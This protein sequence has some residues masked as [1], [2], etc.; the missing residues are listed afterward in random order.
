[1]EKREWMYYFLFVPVLIVIICAA[2]LL[3]FSDNDI[4]AWI[5]ATVAIWLYFLA[6]RID[7]LN[8]RKLNKKPTIPL[9]QIPTLELVENKE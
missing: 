2:Y 5:L 6:D 3:W 1:M 8:E 7:K 4:I 9:E